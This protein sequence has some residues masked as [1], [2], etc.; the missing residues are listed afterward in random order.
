[1]LF[2]YSL[3]QTL[4]YETIEYPVP[5]QASESS[6]F[7]DHDGRLYLIAFCEIGHICSLVSRIRSDASEED[8][9]QIHA[10]L[11]NWRSSLPSRVK[12]Q[13]TLLYWYHEATFGLENACSMFTQTSNSLP[14]SSTLYHL[15]G[16]ELALSSARDVLKFLASSACIQETGLD[17]SPCPICV[18]S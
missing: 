15:A 3:C 10:L 16:G 17:S 1:M 13:N 9:S 12:M 6:A 14:S 11:R 18:P 2:L 7:H 4:T 5:S 8:I